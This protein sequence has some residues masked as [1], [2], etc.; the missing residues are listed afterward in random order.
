MFILA[1]AEW[2]RGEGL[3]TRRPWV[4]AQALCQLGCGYIA[5]REWLRSGY[6]RSS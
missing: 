4:R 1:I 6:C 3:T 5:A 2:R